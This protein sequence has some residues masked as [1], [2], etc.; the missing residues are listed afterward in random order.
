MGNAG[1]AMREAEEALGRGNGQGATDAQ[2]RALRSL[3]QGAQGLA[4][5]MQEGQG[6]GQQGQPG[7]PGGRQGQAGNQDYDP[8]GRPTRGR[9]ANEN[10]DV[11][12]PNAGEGAAQRAQRVLE[13]LRRRLSDQD[14]PQIEMEY[15][16]RLL[17]GLQIQ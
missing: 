6:Q 1:R 9:E 8:L 13:E 14:R 11:R 16:E 5:Q 17:R 12:I 7:Q 10:S 15:I 3:Q 4:Q 2:G